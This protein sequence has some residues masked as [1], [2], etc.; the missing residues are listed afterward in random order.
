MLSHSLSL[1]LPTSNVDEAV[2]GDVEHAEEAEARLE[3]IRHRLES[4]AIHR[5]AIDR[6]GLTEYLDHSVR[7]K[8]AGAAVRNDGCVS[9]SLEGAQTTFKCRMFASQRLLILAARESRDCRLGLKLARARPS[10]YRRHCTFGDVCGNG[11]YGHKACSLVAGPYNRSNC[12]ASHCGAHTRIP[13]RTHTV[14]HTQA[15]A[16][17]TIQYT[18]WVGELYGGLQDQV[19][20]C[21]RHPR[22]NAL[23]GVPR[24]Q[25][26]QGPRG[27]VPEKQ[28]A[29]TAASWSFEISQG[30]RACMC[31]SCVCWWMH[32]LYMPTAGGS[33]H[34][35]SDQPGIALSR[36][37][38]KVVCPR[39]GPPDGTAAPQGCACMT[40]DRAC[41]SM[42]DRGAYALRTM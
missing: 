2:V 33:Q 38:R 3:G 8:W 27:A 20:R 12:S 10:Q 32:W 41:I 15:I 34:Q 31:S 42:R 28:L 1:C 4:V 22:A 40:D 35:S 11:Q 5:Q 21:Q 39:A 36:N 13:H 37:D 6:L 9:Q 17:Q 14:V 25:V 23:Q 30:N 24:R 7:V 18:L 16:A 19:Q 29:D 26:A